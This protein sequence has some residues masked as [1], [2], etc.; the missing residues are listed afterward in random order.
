VNGLELKAKRN[1]L[2]YEICFK[3]KEGRNCIGLIILF[4][5]VLSASNGFAMTIFA[6]LEMILQKKLQIFLFF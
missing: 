1:A 4:S 2:A 5:I 6:K 3:I